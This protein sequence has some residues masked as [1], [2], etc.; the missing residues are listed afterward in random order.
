MKSSY[1]AIDGLCKYCLT[2]QS[3][4][5]YRFCNSKCRYLHYEIKEKMDHLFSP[6]VE[7]KSLC[8]WFPSANPDKVCAR[9]YI[10]HSPAARCQN[11][12]KCS[13]CNV[14]D[15]MLLCDKC[16]EGI[17]SRQFDLI[18]SAREIDSQLR[19]NQDFHNAATVPIIELK[20]AINEN[21]SISNKDEVLK[22]ELYKRVMHFQSV[23]FSARNE[24][25][26]AELSL[27]VAKHN[28]DEVAHLLRKEQRE[29]LKIADN[30]YIPPVKLKPVKIKAVKE[31]KSDRDKFED[32]V[33]SFASMHKISETDARISTIQWYNQMG[34]KV[35]E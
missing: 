9:S 24:V 15:S 21:S 23:L 1:Y 32:L 30:N 28:L 27:S 7:N 3:D 29:A 19:S 5:N 22:E 2:A 25:Y 8:G 11:C 33:K 16:A 13:Y 14:V 12:N 17:K 31:A 10:D 20:K 4:I 26:Q 6:S 18:E 35:P 34:K